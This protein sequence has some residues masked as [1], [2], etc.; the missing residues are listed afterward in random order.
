VA[1]DGALYDVVDADHVAGKTDASF[2]PNQVLAVG[3][4]PHPILDGK[5][6]RRLVDR[7]EA[8]L[9]TPVGLRSLA[10][11]EKEYVGIYSGG[12]GERDH[13]YHQG[14]VWPWLFGP[15]VEAWLRVRGDTPS[16]RRTARERFVAPMLAQAR[17][18]RA[19]GT[20]RRSRTATSPT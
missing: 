14:T 4:L 9:V 8:E 12:P 6:A 16:A 19:S 3:G 15:F 7:V 10:C 20:C 5:N 11:W 2:R 18:G 1:G 17:D 13:A